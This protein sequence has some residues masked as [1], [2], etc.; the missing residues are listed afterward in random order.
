[1]SDKQ[2]TIADIIAEKWRIADEIERDCAEKMKRGEMVSDR[3]ARELVTEIRREADRLEAAWKRDTLQL[4]REIEHLK[5]ERNKA[6]VRERERLRKNGFVIVPQELLTK[7]ADNVNSGAASDSR[8]NSGDAAKLR[9]AIDKC[10]NLI[11]EFG[12]AEIVKT[13]LDVIIDIEAILK[14]AL[15]APPRNCD[16]GTPD[17]QMERFNRFC[18]SHYNGPNG[19]GVIPS[20][21]DCPCQGKDGCNA[22][23]WEQMPYEADAQKGGE[24]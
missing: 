10:V 1:M 2:E 20:G 3:Y 18:V 16:V 8:D 17:E 21:C 5:D 13:T 19:H 23:V 7:P 22:F 9:E 4:R 12:N 6:P 14:A 11:T 24:E 15:A